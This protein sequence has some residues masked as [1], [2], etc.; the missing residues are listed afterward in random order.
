MVK[1]RLIKKEIGSEMS[2]LSSFRILVGM[3]LGPDDFDVENDP[4][5]LVT[6]L[7]VI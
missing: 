7:G 5:I 6:S 1:D 3:L 4:I 2:H